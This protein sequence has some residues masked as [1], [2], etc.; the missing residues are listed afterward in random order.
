[1]SCAK[2]RF[3][4]ETRTTALRD[5]HTLSLVP[6]PP[7]AHTLTSLSLKLSPAATMSDSVAAKSGFLCMYMS[8]HPDTLVSYVRYWGKVTEGVASAKMTSIDTKVRVL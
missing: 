4:A 2:S 8:S 3:K 7:H 6:P 5:S 1:M